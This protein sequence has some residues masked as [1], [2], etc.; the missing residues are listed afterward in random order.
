MVQVYHSCIYTQ[1]TELTHME[2]QAHQCLLL[3]YL[4]ELKNAP[5]VDV[6][7]TAKLI[8]KDMLYLHSRVLVIKKNESWQENAKNKP[9]S[10]K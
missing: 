2:M 4:Q 3:G 9:D 7:S 5:S 6:S 1:K 8:K 10:V